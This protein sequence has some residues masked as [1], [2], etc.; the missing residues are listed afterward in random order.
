VNS[1]LETKDFL[2]P[3]GL[4]KL[5][6]PKAVL[7]FNKKYFQTYGYCNTLPVLGITV[8]NNSVTGETK[9]IGQLGG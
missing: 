4:I 5:V 2:P 9:V 6:V 8:L 7:V 1:Y 3:L